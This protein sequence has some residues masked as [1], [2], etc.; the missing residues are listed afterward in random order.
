MSL[1]AP[2]RRSASQKSSTLLPGAFLSTRT[3]KPILVT[4][5][6]FRLALALLTITPIF[7]MGTCV[8]TRKSLTI[9]LMKMAMILSLMIGRC[10]I[11]CQICVALLAQLSLVH[12]TAM[13][14]ASPETSSVV[15]AY[16]LLYTYVY[17]Y[18]CIY[19]YIYILE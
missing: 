3:I 16:M 18:I 13:L 7:Q 17:I 12:T 4:L 19:I 5:A 1:F 8:C 2:S 6:D 15:P 10:P 14:R 11:L 9:F